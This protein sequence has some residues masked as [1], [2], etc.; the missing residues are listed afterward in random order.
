MVLVTETGHRVAF[1]LE[2]TTKAPERRERILAG[3]AADPRIDA[4]IYLVDR[5]TVG[6]AI[7]RSAAR[8]GISDLVRVQK[9][10]I[11]AAAPPVGDGRVADRRHARGRPA[12]EPAAGAGR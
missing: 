1:E 9:V 8:V 4:V 12:G 10:T 7:E 11:G 6:R 2:L 3:Y 5:A